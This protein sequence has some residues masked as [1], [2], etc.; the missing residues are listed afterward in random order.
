L[1]ADFAAS[2]L[3][4]DMRR[5]EQI[6]PEDFMASLPDFLLRDKKHFLDMVAAPRRFTELK[7]DG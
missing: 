6:V 2:A 7:A 3:N 4:G 1:N 5:F